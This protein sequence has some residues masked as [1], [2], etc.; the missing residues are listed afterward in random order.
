VNRVGGLDRGTF[1]GP[2]CRVGLSLVAWEPTF[3]RLVGMVFVCSRCLR[4]AKRES[5][6]S[7]GLS[8]AGRCEECSDLL[9]SSRDEAADKDFGGERVPSVGA[10]E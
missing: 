4:R 8:S 1:D 9:E 5:A 10:L 7:S 6:V 2:L 3:A